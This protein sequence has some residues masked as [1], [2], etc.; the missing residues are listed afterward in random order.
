[1]ADFE[2]Q[3]GEKF[4]EKDEDAYD[5]LVKVEPAARAYEELNVK[6]VITGRRK[7]QGA[8]RASLKVLEYDERGLLKVNP[9]IEWS[10]KQVKDY[11]DAK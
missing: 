4:W 6:A 11:V 2:S 9:L 5:Y 8:D 3:H 10:F 7:S 1:V